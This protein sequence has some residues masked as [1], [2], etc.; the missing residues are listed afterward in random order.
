MWQRACRSKVP[1]IRTILTNAWSTSPVGHS[2]HEDWPVLI[3]G[4]ITACLYHIIHSEGIIAIHTHC[5][6]AVPRP[7]TGWNTRNRILHQDT[8]TLDKVH[9]YVYKSSHKTIGQLVLAFWKWPFQSLTKICIH[10]P[11]PSPR[12]CSWLGVEIAYPLLRLKHKC[13]FFIHI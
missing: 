12:Y 11:I 7:S 8:R 6:H 10:S 1:N 4:Q 3:Q 2:F 13:I 9:F 5:G